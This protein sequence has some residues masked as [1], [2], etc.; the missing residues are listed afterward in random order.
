M[1]GNLVTVVIP[2][3]NAEKTIDATL[4]SV[5]SQTHTELEVL[6]VDDGSG[7]STRDI[8]RRH[9]AE[10]GRIRL[11]EQANQGVAA[12]RNR[13]IAEA[14][15]DLVAPLDADDLFHPDKILKQAAL[16]RAAGTGVGLVYCWCSTI[17]ELGRVVGNRHRPTA[18]G[19]VFAQLCRENMVGN[20]SSPLI[21]KQALLETGGYDPS[22][23]ARK[24]GGCEDLK[25]YLQIAE[26]HEFRVVKEF[27]L[28]YRR[29]LNNMSS[30]WARM[31]R[32]FDIVAAEFEARLPQTAADFRAGRNYMLR[33]L[34]IRSIREARFGDSLGIIRA[35]FALDWRFAAKALTLL[36]FQGIAKSFDR[37]GA[38][39]P[40]GGGEEAPVPLAAPG[41]SATES[42]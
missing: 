5:R 25:I 21:S 9:S 13:G 14:R 6:V 39:F 10:D 41:P 29:V 35:M 12:A 1:P 3:Y 32:S 22:L 42:R 11:I 17:D 31:Y 38:R 30:D 4:R 18:E 40:S 20:G 8:V 23:R 15:G 37:L 7:D 26:R 19:N 2:A 28:G 36:P 27:L 24:A 33:F 34:L 16:M